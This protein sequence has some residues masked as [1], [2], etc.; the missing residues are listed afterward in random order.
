MS[1]APPLLPTLAKPE[2]VASTQTYAHLLGSL[3]LVETPLSTG[4]LGLEPY[5]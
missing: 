4:Q 1:T 5:E 3:S 2:V